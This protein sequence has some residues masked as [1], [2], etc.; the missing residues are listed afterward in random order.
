MRP[1][2]RELTIKRGLRY[3]SDTELVMLILGS[4]TKTCPVERLSSMVMNAI[5]ISD[6]NNLVENLLKIKGMGQGK[7]LQVA[8]AYE[9]GRR[10]NSKNAAVVKKPSDIV[11][12]I[13]N[14]SVQQKEHFLCIT[15]TGAHEII[16][17]RVI[18]IGTVNR[19]YVHPREVFCE[20][21][22][23][24]AAAIIVA[25]N[26]PSGNCNPSKD[27]IVTTENLIK[28]ANLLGIELLDHIIFDKNSYFSFM[29]N[30]LLF[31]ER[32][33]G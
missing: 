31:A 24:D 5:M 17:I 12:F 19:T 27:D 22:K 2:I 6:E 21:I 11:P 23:E 20:A 25:H 13:K 29:E 30:N 8:A 28:C 4:G 3:A 33:A 9:L 10:L 32:S 1:D 14:Y 18:S 15:L 7:A 16:Q 26:H